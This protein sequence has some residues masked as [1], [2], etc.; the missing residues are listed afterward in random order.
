[1]KIDQQNI[2]S[3]GSSQAAAAVT[4]TGQRSSVAFGG[5]GDQAELSGIS[6]AIQSFQSDRAARIDRLT[7][8]VRSGKYDASSTHVGSAIVSDALNAGSQPAGAVAR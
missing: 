8:L 1:M 2:A 3:A 5:G 7:A 4:A 6:K